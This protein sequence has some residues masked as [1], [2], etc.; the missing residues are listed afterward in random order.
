[1]DELRRDL[2]KAGLTKQISELSPKGY[3]LLWGK[4]REM[5]STETM[6]I[7]NGIVAALLLAVGALIWNAERTG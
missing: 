6:K 7:F 1:M 3:R 2:P 5:H 4:K